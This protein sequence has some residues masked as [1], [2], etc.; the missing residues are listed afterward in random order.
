MRTKPH[1]RSPD[2]DDVWP[3][4]EVEPPPPEPTRLTAVLQLHHSH[5]RR[6]ASFDERFHIV[7]AGNEQ[8]A[9]AFDRIVPVPQ[10]A[11]Q[12]IELGH[13]TAPVMVAITNISGTELRANPTDA[14]R[15]AIDASVIY[16]GP[17][18]CPKVCPILPWGSAVVLQFNPAHPWLWW[19]PIAGVEARVFAAP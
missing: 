19:S 17:A 8:P 16:C 6:Q 5:R 9:E 13:V 15:S 3:G 2:P 18:E 10:G 7:R 14:E 4:D 12:P 11:A 1:L